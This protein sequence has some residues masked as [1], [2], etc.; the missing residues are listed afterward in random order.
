MQTAL[1]IKQVLIE[2]LERVGELFAIDLEHIADDKLAVTAMGVARSP[3]NI[4]A[5]VIYI[6]NKIADVV[7]GTP[8]SMIGDE[9]FGRFSDSLDSREKGLV[10]LQASIAKLVAAFR[11]VPDEALDAPVDAPW[12]EAST[13]YRLVNAAQQHMF[14]H[15]GQLNYIQSL[16]G[17]G[18]NHWSSS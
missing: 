16:Y 10:A 9:E 4:T 13:R 1:D 2:Q 17:D 7:Q 18:V 12:G 14:Y 11:T 3:L 15:S 8:T 5:E 6:N